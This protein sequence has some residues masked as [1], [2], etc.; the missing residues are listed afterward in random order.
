MTKVETPTR[1]RGARSRRGDGA[2]WRGWKR[3]AR[4]GQ[5]SGSRPPKSGRGG[6]G[7]IDPRISARRTAVI[8]EQGR[9]RLR[10]LAIGLAGTALLIG[11]WF[12][13]HTP[14]FGARA[15]TVTGNLHESAAQVIDQAGLGSH[16]PLLDVDAG[17]TAARIE[18]LPWV[19]SAS[20]S[21]SWPDGAQ[22][23]I[24]EETPRFAVS[25]AGGHWAAVSA[26]GRVLAVS[27]AREDGLL[28]LAVPQA[29]GAPGSVLSARDD[30]GLD[31]ASTLP[32]SFAAQVTGVTV[33]PAGWVQ[34]SMTTPIA[35]DVGTATQLTAK[36][37]DVS[38]ILAG[39][40]LHNGDVID[41]SV[42]D[43]PTVTGP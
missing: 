13:L 31:V 37:E 14:L 29:P 6:G 32:V 3:W 10:I 38:S 40:T 34:L 21:V 17:A 27:V 30:A 25:E 18:Q 7:R 16:P 42:P 41:V 8:R 43:A 2:G 36:Y 35:V 11:V 9:R 23:K 28:L 20:V 24:T 1:G 5:G 4:G 22:I 33:E 15:V 12:L 26:D 19:K 39:A